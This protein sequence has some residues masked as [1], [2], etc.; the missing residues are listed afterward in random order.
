MTDQRPLPPYVG[1]T[2]GGCVFGHPGGMHT[3]GGCHCLDELRELYGADPDGLYARVRSA[4]LRLRMRT[5]RAEAEAKR[6]NG[7][8][9][10]NGRCRCGASVHCP[11]CAGQAPA[12]PCG[13]CD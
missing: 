8:G 13:C 2:D 5:E 6:R 9:P 1:C 4:L 11:A 3:N 10:L 12:C 7:S